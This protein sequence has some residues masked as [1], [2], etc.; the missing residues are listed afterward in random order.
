MMFV[1]S[2]FML[3]TATA[4][5]ALLAVDASYARHHSD[6]V[7]DRSRGAHWGPGGPM[8][9]DRAAAASM[10]PP[11]ARTRLWAAAGSAAGMGMVLLVL[12]A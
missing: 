5:L 2:F 9:E 3:F 11:G 6:D 4:T 7:L 1:L 10:L 12:A 8:I